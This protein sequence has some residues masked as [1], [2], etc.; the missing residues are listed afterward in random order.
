MALLDEVGLLSDHAADGREALERAAAHDYALILMDV[1]MPRMDGLEATRR[2][3]QL[4]A[5]RRVPILAM[6]AN[7]FDQDR[8]RCLE[9]GMDDF[10][11][12][13]VAPEHFY[14]RVL[15]WLSRA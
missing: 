1:Q 6:T 12:K 14:G 11:A 10:I 4:P 15:K 9:A 5:G 13:P 7:S 2:I 3:R 8:Q